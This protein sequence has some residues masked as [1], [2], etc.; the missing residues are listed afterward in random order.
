V[1]VFDRVEFSLGDKVFTIIKKGTG[2][3]IKNITC[4]NFPINDYFIPHSDL[5]KGSELIIET[6]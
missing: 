6:E 5:E 3:K 1:P 2:R 4:D